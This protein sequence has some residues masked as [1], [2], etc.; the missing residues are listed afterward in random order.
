MSSKTESKEVTSKTFEQL[1]PEAVR[2]RVQT[3]EG[4]KKSQ[5][6]KLEKR[7]EAHQKGK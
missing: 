5:M 7:K 4:L 6:K 3:A 1:H 2:Q